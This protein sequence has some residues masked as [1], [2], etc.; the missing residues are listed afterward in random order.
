MATVHRN[1]IPPKRL[2]HKK[3]ETFSDMEFKEDQIVDWLKENIDHR[4]QY[5]Y[6]VFNG[7]KGKL[8]R[9]IEF[10]VWFQTKQ[11]AEK[12]SEVWKK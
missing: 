10:T 2:L 12:F 7:S 11:D 4:V 9:T 6:T 5:D 1:G 8:N 3:I